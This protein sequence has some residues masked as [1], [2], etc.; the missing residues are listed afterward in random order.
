MANLDR[1]RADTKEEH[2]VFF[3]LRAEFRHNNIQ[4][5]FGGSVQRRVFDLGIVDPV[6]VA[7]AAG[8]GNHLLDFAFHDKREEEGEEVDISDDVGLE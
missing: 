8:N 7:V 6:E 5:R 2:A 3:V 1:S 4:G